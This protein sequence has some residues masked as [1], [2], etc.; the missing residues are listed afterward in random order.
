MNSILACYRVFYD[1][2]YDYFFKQPSYQKIER[3]YPI[4]T[5]YDYFYNIINQY[6]YFFSNPTHIIDNIY[7]GSAFNSAS[8][9]TLKNLN[10]KKII[11]VTKEITPYFNENFEYKVYKLYDNNHDNISD[12]LEDSYEYINNTNDNILVHCYM[13]SSRSA[14]IVIYYL[15]KKYDMT[16]EDSIKF[17]KEKRNIVNLTT[18][19]KDE[20]ELN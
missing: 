16:L 17:V 5:Y 11:N 8:Y 18:K 9:Y 15:M 13:G 4:N 7:L 12:Y 14:S 1:K 2:T 19:F 3:I 10:I 6:Y 20:L